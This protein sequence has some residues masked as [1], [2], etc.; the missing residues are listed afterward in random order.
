MSQFSGEKLTRITPYIRLYIPRDLNDLGSQ[1]RSYTKSALSGGAKQCCVSKKRTSKKDQ[2]RNPAC[3][4][5][6]RSD[7]AADRSPRIEPWHASEPSCT[8][9]LSDL[10]I[11]ADNAANKTIGKFTPP[12]FSLSLASFA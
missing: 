9:R 2:L 6:D 8:R 7:A 10:D 3:P 1:R 4:T 5:G 11:L 12:I